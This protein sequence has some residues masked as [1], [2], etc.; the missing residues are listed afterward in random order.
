MFPQLYFNEFPSDY[1]RIALSEIYVNPQLVPCRRYTENCLKADN[2]L[3]HSCFYFNSRNDLNW[4]VLLFFPRSFC[5]PLALSFHGS[6]WQEAVLCVMAEEFQS[7]RAN[8]VVMDREAKKRVTA[9]PTYSLEAYDIVNS[10]RYPR[11]ESPCCLRIFSL[12]ACSA[13]TSCP[14]WLLLDSVTQSIPPFS[15]PYEAPLC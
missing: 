11:I 7:L 8:E 2:I 9:I 14:T 3:S 5:L 13:R 12:C 1:L 6:P 4:T 10:L 15:L